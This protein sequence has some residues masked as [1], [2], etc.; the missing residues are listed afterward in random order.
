MIRDS[1]TVGSDTVEK[2]LRQTVETVEGD[3]MK[4]FAMMS[5]GDALAYSQDPAKIAEGEK[6]IAE[7]TKQ[8]ISVG[9]QALDFDAQTIDGHDFKLSD[10]RGK[11]VLVDFYGFW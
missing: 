10:Y 7:Y 3:A 11:V 4:A 1:R 9:A 5:L 8:F 2:L 6:L